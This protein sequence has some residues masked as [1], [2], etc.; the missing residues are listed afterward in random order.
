MKLPA[1]GFLAW[2]LA[3]GTAL[4]DP[5][6]LEATA[7]PLEGSRFDVKVVPD[8]A[9]ARVGE[10]AFDDTLVFLGG[11]VVTIEC[12]KAGFDATPYSVTSSGPGWKF[13]TEQKSDREGKSVWTAEIL[14][15]T[16]RGQRTWTRKDGIVLEYTFTGKRVV[17]AG[18][19]TGS[20]DIERYL[21][22]RSA[23]SPSFSPD[24][25][26][27]AFLTNIT[28]THQ[29]WK[30]EDGGGWPEQLTF[31]PDRVF[32]ASW[33]PRGDWITFSKDAGGDE[34]Y[35]IHL[36]SPDGE[37]L[38]AL[39]GDPRV[40]HNLGPWSKDGT[41]L[42]YSSNEREA[43]FFDLYVVNVDTRERRRV[44]AKDALFY[45]GPF[46]NDGTKL[47]AT[48]TNA[49]QDSDLF[50]VDLAAPAG[51]EP[52]LLTSHEGIARFSAVGFTPDDRSVWVVTDVGRE[53]L[54]LG[55]IDL[56]SRKISFDREARWDVSSAS[57]TR[58]GKTL[59]V[60]TNED[61]YDVLSLIESQ[62]TRVLPAPRMP[63]GQVGG[64]AF[65][66]DGQRLAAS[67][68]GSTR[69]SDIWIADLGGEALAR[70]TRSSTA[71][72]PP[73]T[74]VE[75]QLVRYRS[76]D[77]L[78]IPA[79]FYLPPGSEK[80]GSLAC[81]VNPHGGPESQTVASFSPTLQ[82]YVNR[83]YA[84]LAP[85]VRGST[86]YGKTFSHLDDVRRREDSVKDLAA[87][88]DWLRGSGYVDPKKIAVM[89]G[90]YGGYMT[91]AAITLYPD[92]WAA[93]VNSFGIANFRTFFGKTASY[94][95]GMRA[96]EYG[97][98]VNDAAFLDTVSPIHKVDRIRAPLLVLQGAN[99]PRVPAAE[100]E[101]IVEA[102][103]RNGGVAEYVLFPDE[104]HGWSKLVN[105][106]KAQRTA[107]DFLDRHLKATPRPA[108]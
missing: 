34:N 107:A 56:A 73:S 18:G 21:N 94:R 27:I 91:L 99:D 37:R 39:T 8:E 33:S 98:P 81:V 83:G 12:Q 90:S 60:V 84:V 103:R 71:G 77:G 11:K 41:W 47:I 108:G 48:R 96:S 30:V 45:P 70:V 13:R 7:S 54:T 78:E 79:F 63:R 50:L 44:V 43:R 85:N 66:L 87:G 46:S 105:Q 23:V 5:V 9:A 20:F 74:F 61:G 106:I 22:I 58:D 100:S 52:D 62:T 16:I 17:R 68:S 29:I 49:S 89:G 93:A 67:L 35:Q 19:G 32:G 55:R 65:S 6:K 72:I 42:A 88:V 102:V 24:G 80:R 14:E 59:A 4:A 36:I 75:P 53:F 92:L 1:A 28:G 101:Q 40:R 38:V 64:L 26:S 25:K 95:V 3:V 57:L 86:G 76:F 51:V 82:Y 10:K 97:D 2:S 31:F 15:D 104:G 69:N